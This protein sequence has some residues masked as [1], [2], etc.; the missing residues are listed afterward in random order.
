MQLLRLHLLALPIGAVIVTGR[1]TSNTD[2]ES[3][4][5]TTQVVLDSTSKDFCKGFNAAT[6]RVNVAAC[7]SLG[8]LTIKNQQDGPLRASKEPGQHRGHG[9][10][11]FAADSQS[12]GQPDGSRRL[13]RRG[14][15]TP[16]RL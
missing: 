4:R 3:P 6:G 16:R 1:L 2:D 12:T 7:S 5:G 11:P 14:K 13:A 9:L 15:A 8:R 10:S